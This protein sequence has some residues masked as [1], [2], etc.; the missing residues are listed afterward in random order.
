MLSA[1]ASHRNDADRSVES[2]L[3]PLAVK[4]GQL[5]KMF[6][7]NFSPQVCKV[8]IPDISF[9]ATCDSRSTSSSSALSA[10]ILL[11]RTPRSPKAVLGLEKAS[12]RAGLALKL[13]P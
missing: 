13:P 4:D 6:G 8:M 5:V 7:G 2:R 12:S 9:F 1:D 11:E 10:L 3:G